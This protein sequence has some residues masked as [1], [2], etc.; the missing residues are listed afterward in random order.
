M[1]LVKKADGFNNEQLFVIPTRFLDKVGENPLSR[2][3]TVTDIGY[4]PN[5]AHHFFERPSGCETAILF[6]CSAGSGLYSIKGP[7]K[8]KHTIQMLGG[9]AKILSPGQIVIF[10]PNT[11]H[12]YQ[13]SETHPWSI[14]WVHVK[15]PFFNAFYEN[16]AP[17]LPL[18]LSN[19]LA[20]R[21]IDIF[22]QCFSILSTPYQ[23]EEFL[24]LCQL[25]ATMFSLINCEGKRSLLPFTEEGDLAL[26]K[27]I[28]FMH[29]HIHET[30]NR[31]QLLG[32]SQVSSSQLTH[33][34]K[35]ATGFAPIEYFLR[36]KIHAASQDL[37]FS[38]LPIRDIADAYGIADPYY[39]SRLF[40]K[41][42]G[43]PPKHYRNRVSG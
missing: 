26:N 13:A 7:Q 6:Y 27:A 35:H 10:P 41:I 4:Y 30:I 36:T 22:R 8:P 9:V 42:M 16:T 17:Y 14:Y 3:L 1:R 28:A 38:K 21:V 34:F 18:R 43:L 40:K 19:I 39:F 2:F 23:T 5:A 20:Q 12:T 31:R 11:P 32:A 24:Y 15:G 37:Y 25:V 29:D 33:L